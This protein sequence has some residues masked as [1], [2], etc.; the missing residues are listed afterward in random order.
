MRAGGWAAS[1]LEA[2]R[3]AARPE[4]GKGPPAK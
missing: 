1:L 4:G 3:P 2:A